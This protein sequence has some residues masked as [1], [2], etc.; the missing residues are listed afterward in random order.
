ME[1][2]FYA[3][4]SAYPTTDE[5]VRTVLAHHFGVENAEIVRNEN[6]KP[7]LKDGKSLFF[8][9]SHTNTKIFIAVSDENVGLDAERAE[10][11]TA[12]H[13]IVKKFSPSERKEIVC[14]QDFLRH[15]TAKEAAVKWLG[16]TLAHD[17]YKLSYINGVLTY[18]EAALPPVSFPFFEGYILAVCGER[19]FSNVQ[20]VPIEI[21]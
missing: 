14:T 19:D 9:V 21:R 20:C 11:E 12:Y 15:F 13:A 8:S 6:G 2:I 17:L 7:Y 18:G 16:G 5:A 1:K 3:D 10:R 4:R